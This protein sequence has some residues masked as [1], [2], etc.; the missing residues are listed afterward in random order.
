MAVLS[1]GPGKTGTRASACWSTT[2]GHSSLRSMQLLWKRRRAPP[3]NRPSFDPDS[4]RAQ[5][6]AMSSKTDKRAKEIL[7]LLL[8]HGKA[9]VDELTSALG[10]SPA[11][12]RRDLVRLE[13]H[14]LVTRTHG[15]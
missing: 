10:T 12:I 9:S 13:I 4:G 14:G 2:C 5:S 8:S 6:A 3:Y 1:W 15:G 7:R 11:S